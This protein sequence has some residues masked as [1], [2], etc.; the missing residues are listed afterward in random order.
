MNNLDYSIKKVREFSKKPIFFITIVS[1][2]DDTRFGYNEY[3]NK[4]MI[5]LFMKY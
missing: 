5:Y 4:I 3:L 1:I 2:F